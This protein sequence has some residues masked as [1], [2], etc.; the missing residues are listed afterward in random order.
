MGNNIC[1]QLGIAP[2]KTISRNDFGSLWVM[3]EDE[4]GKMSREHAI[5]FLADFAH[6]SGVKYDQELAGK[7]VDSALES[8]SKKDGFL[9]YHEFQKLFFS[10]A[11]NEKMNLT[12]SLQVELNEAG[13]PITAKEKLQKQPASAGSAELHD[14]WEVVSEALLSFFNPNNTSLR[15]SASNAKDWMT[16]YSTVYSYCTSPLA[17]VV[18]LYKHIDNF[19]EKQAGSIVAHTRTAI[20]SNP[21]LDLIEHYLQEWD[22]Y[23]KA[24]QRT[25][26]ILKVLNKFVSIKLPS[27]LSVIELCWAQ[28][29]SFYM[30][31]LQNELLAS[32]KAHVQKENKTD[33]DVEVIKKAIKSC[34]T[35]ELPLDIFEP[36]C[37]VKPFLDHLPESEPSSLTA[38]TDDSTVSAASAASN[39]NPPVIPE[40]T[41]S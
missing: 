34:L 6:A 8:S 23:H 4:K 40:T 18:G 29:A 24:A 15:K 11:K 32:F 9:D 33:T 35:V 38:S 31:P 3:Y 22:V 39:Q 26:T 30:Q 28:W 5:R 20:S 27:Q 2:G 41:T 16:V 1:S 25:N 37:D 10:I 17:D 19:L 14:I 21:N 12:Q 13:D 36:H 7:L